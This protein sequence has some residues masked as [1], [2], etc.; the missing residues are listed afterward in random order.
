MLHT[1]KILSINSDGV[2]PMLSP[3]FTYLWVRNY[4]KSNSINTSKV[5]PCICTQFLK[6]SKL[7][8]FP[9]H[10]KTL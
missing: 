2:Q 3:N 4:K 10:S 6:S 5:S 8:V 1:S 9:C 7:I